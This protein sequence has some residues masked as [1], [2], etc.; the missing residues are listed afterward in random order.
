MM[1]AL[2]F[3]LFSFFPQGSC[4]GFLD[5][6]YSAKMQLELEFSF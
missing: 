3:S 2:L 1:S 4:V 5:I 6:C